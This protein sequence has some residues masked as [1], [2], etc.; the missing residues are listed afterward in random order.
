LLHDASRALRKR[1]EQRTSDLGLSSAQ[2]RLLLLVC[3]EPGCAQSR[4]AD[5]L[6]IEP[7]SVSRLIDRMVS[8][9]WLLRQ[10]DPKDRRVKLVLPTPRALSA[11]HHIK[12]IADDVYAEALVGVSAT[13]A[14]LLIRGLRQI[15]D[16]L[17]DAAEPACT[18]RP[19]TTLA[20]ADP[21]S[22]P[23]AGTAPT[24]EPPTAEP[25]TAG[26][27]TAGPPTAESL[28]V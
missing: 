25:P 5:A 17:T 6:D 10:D 23:G 7:I 1:F 20:G 16:N 19:A 28:T 21:G 2:W 12:A 26:P 13:E 4:F 14:Q 18:A 11:Y 15:I 3:R 9:G 8:G 22:G 24:A 27:P